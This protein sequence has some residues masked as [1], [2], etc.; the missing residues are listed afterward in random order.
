MPLLGEHFRFGVI[1]G[2]LV[3]GVAFAL[4]FYAGLFPDFYTLLISFI[5]GFIALVIGSLLP[6]MDAPRS[7]VHDTLLVF[8]GGLATTIGQHLISTPLAILA[9]SFLTVWADRNYLPSHRGFIHSFGAALMFGLLFS[10]TL[11]IFVTKNIVF[12]L[13]CGFSLMVG[14]LLH[15]RKDGIALAFPN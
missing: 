15:L 2:G 3:Y 11:Y 8:F 12:C 4:A 9:A 6:D 5:F 7:P 10:V 1:V 13:W 14:H